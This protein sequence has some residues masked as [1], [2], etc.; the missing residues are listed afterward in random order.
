MQLHRDYNSISAQLSLAQQLHGKKEQDLALNICK[1]LLER[2]KVIE[3]ARLERVNRLSTL[4]SVETE[5]KK[6]PAA[7]MS[8][9]QL[10][11]L[12]TI[13]AER[14]LANALPTEV[15]YDQVANFDQALAIA[16][17]MFHSALSKRE[18]QVQS[19]PELDD[20]T[21]DVPVAQVRDYVVSYILNPDHSLNLAT[22]LTTALGGNERRYGDFI[23]AVPIIES[24]ITR[25]IA[26]RQQMTER[27]HLIIEQGL[28]INEEERMKKIKK[29][30][31]QQ[32][33]R[34]AEI[35]EKL[36]A[37]PAKY[38]FDPEDISAYEQLILK[39]ATKMVDLAIDAKTTLQQRSTDQ[40]TKAKLTKK[41]KQALAAGLDKSVDPLIEK[42]V[43][44]SLSAGH[45]ESPND[46]LSLE[47]LLFRRKQY[48]LV[49]K[50]GNKLR[51]VVLE[52]KKK[53]DT[54]T[55]LNVEMRELQDER[56]K[57]LAA[58]KVLEE[59]KK[60]RLDQL[61]FE[62]ELEKKFQPKHF[63]LRW[64]QLD[65]LEYQAVEMIVDAI[66]SMEKELNER[67]E[68]AKT[69][70]SG[71]I[72]PTAQEIAEK[73][74][75]FREQ[76][77]YLLSITNNPEHLFK[78]AK[79]IQDK[80]YKDS[81]T[82]LKF[83][84]KCQKHMQQ[85]EM[86]REQRAPI[87]SECDSTK[88][89]IKDLVNRKREV[90]DQLPATVAELEKKLAALPEWPEFADLNNPYEYDELNLDVV[91]V[92]TSAILDN[93]I[94]LE[95]RIKK[96]F[97]ETE[98]SKIDHKQIEADR[99]DIQQRIRSLVKLCLE[100]F[101]NP[102]YLLKFARNMNARKEMEIVL[103]VSDK[104]LD[105]IQHLQGLRKQRAPIQKEY[106]A[107]LADNNAPN[108]ENRLKELK[109]KLDKLPVWPHFA[110]LFDAHQHDSTK[111]NITLLALQRVLSAQEEMEA[112]ISKQIYQ[113]KTA[114][115]EKKIAEERDA[116]AAHL[117]H[118]IKQCIAN[119]DNPKDLN[120]VA[121]TMRSMNESSVIL[122][123][124]PK[125]YQVLSELEQ[126]RVIK[127]KTEQF[128]QMLKKEQDVLHRI[129]REL[130]A[131]VKAE[132]PKLQEKLAAMEL[133][134]W[135]G[136]A[137][138]H[139]DLRN[140]LTR[141]MVATT[142]TKNEILE[143]KVATDQEL[144][145]DRATHLKEIVQAQEKKLLDLVLKYNEDPWYLIEAIREFR[146]KKKFDA[147]ITLGN[148]CRDK[149][150]EL[151]L[152]AKEKEDHEAERKKLVKEEEDLDR[153]RK[154]LPEDKKKRLRDLELEV[155]LNKLEP[156]YFNHTIKE[157]DGQI[158]ELSKLIVDSCVDLRTELEE[159][160]KTSGA[161]ETE[162]TEQ[163]KEGLK[164][165]LDD[166]LIKSLDCIDLVDNMIAFAKHLF[167]KREFLSVL[168]VGLKTE[169]KLEEMRNELVKREEMKKDFE[170][171]DNFRLQRLVSA[172]SADEKAE[173]ADL[174]QKVQKLKGEIEAFGAVAYDNE[175]I[176]KWVLDI[177]HYTVE[178]AKIENI[179]DQL[180]QQLIL[181]FKAD[182]TT[183]RWDSIRAMCSEE[184][185][186]H[187]KTDL[188]V[189]VLNNTSYNNNA[190]IE[191]L[192]KDGLYEH[193][194]SLFPK[195]EGNDGEIE[196][197]MKLWKGVE[198]SKPELLEHMI[199]HVARYVKRYCQ[200]FKFEELNELIDR[201]QRRFPAIIVTLYNT[202]LDMVMI[203]VMPS[204]YGAVVECLRSLRVRLC[205]TLDRQDDWAA[206]FE[207]FKK[208]HKSKKKMIQMI[209][210]IGDS[211]L[212][213]RA[214][215][216]ANNAALKKE[217][218]KSAPVRKVGQKAKRATSVKKA[219]A[220]TPESDEVDDDEEE[221]EEDVDVEE[222]DDEEASTPKKKKVKTC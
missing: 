118:A 174:E 84:E 201:V 97:Q 162:E 177:T 5:I 200:E 169:D 132:I 88:Q 40:W 138:T 75:S 59:P 102:E 170:V 113:D 111:Q 73:T 23:L 29:L 171:L 206:F 126:Q 202:A 21:H 186:N 131:D 15:L 163:E 101:S 150:K 80:N 159:K 9:E 98:P 57:A 220:H 217:V 222:D 194:I 13:D 151:K 155:A 2:L 104:C 54:R 122:A 204:Q 52:L 39:L 12:K 129:K 123:I 119:I 14:T 198:E 24:A 112:R 94:A 184:E 188:V 68:L 212:D 187:V 154:Q 62:Y 145:P 143:R 106:D 71:V 193:C 146:G 92:M 1:E 139:M 27:Y 58:W 93:K 130:P 203:N 55:Q 91:T 199:Q 41:E 87:Q 31:P 192:M 96:M 148:H 172:K 95:E 28:L 100:K 77:D 213:L 65:D 135:L 66:K 70:N 25:V 82:V 43:E 109:D 67:I 64:K 38:Y 160:I 63:Q 34:L 124:A 196:L 50:V 137:A 185:W 89:K 208:K 183:E 153:L 85:I 56:D 141:M 134:P 121:T 179:E 161:M 175:K 189:F 116:M 197:I 167:D 211:Q 61:E 165:L 214:M 72:A 86:W 156:A 32:T 36:S 168:T 11:H 4:T 69:A 8:K 81:E 20:I 19:T 10:K 144:T 152:R 110:T 207:E 158:V 33:T 164:R 195:P 26:L 45:L 17:Q 7:Q 125:T 48:Q 99:K 83:G 218:K 136:N 60:K 133:P 128:L 176:N 205:D 209:T 210:L 117:E 180:R 105:R 157:Y 44:M 215:V 178:S 79:F 78:V 127:D 173:L 140:S 108:K 107:V 182:T 30:S 46:I 190:K 3:A 35:K 51:E 191:L 166:E 37:M 49:L 6:T 42:V 216:A 47:Q 115:N 149:L 114:V 74:K 147:A 120:Q 221:K 18:E 181:A 22:I 219:K 142:L 16:T 90:P 103:E 53:K 76:L